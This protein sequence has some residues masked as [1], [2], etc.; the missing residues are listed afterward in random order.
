MMVQATIPQAVEAAGI[1]FPTM[2]MSFSY[3]RYLQNFY[4]THIRIVFWSVGAVRLWL[5]S[6]SYAT[7]RY[8]L[9]TRATKNV[10]SW[11]WI[12]GFF[13]HLGIALLMD[14]VRVM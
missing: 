6:T 5:W 3:K 10:S 13:Y 2:R 4:R 1:F 14:A 9:S 7:S 12:L 11:I 8:C